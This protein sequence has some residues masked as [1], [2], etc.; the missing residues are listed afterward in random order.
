MSDTSATYDTT[1]TLTANEFTRAGYTFTG[2]NTEADGSGTSYEDG[3][4]VSNLTT[5]DGDTVTLY[6][7]WEANPATI[8]VYYIDK[9]TGETLDTYS[10]T[11]VYG[12][13]V[14]TSASDIEGYVLV[15]S[16]ETEEYILDVEDINVYYYY[17]ETV[18]VTITKV[19]QE[20]SSTT[21]SGVEFSLY[22]LICED[23]SHEHDTDEDLIDTEDY[24]TTTCWELVGE[25]TTDS[26]GEFELT[27]LPITR[28]YRLVETKTIENYL[29]PT[30]QWKIEFDYDDNLDESSSITIDDV[31]LQIT[32]IGNPPALSLQTVNGEDVLYLYN[33]VAYDIPTTGSYDTNN[34]YLVGIP[35]ML[36]GVLVLVIRKRQKHT[37][38]RYSSLKQSVHD[39]RKI[40]NN[41][42]KEV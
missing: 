26:N 3:A 42:D 30:G 27:N 8:N 41:W 9:I 10:Y 32:A 1:V 17:E 21:L 40:I 11:G 28:N 13:T 7:Q 6:A 23:D 14:T 38:G 24:D 25:Y 4:T 16:P 2:W 31:T 35:I 20:D 15:E 29:L 22:E 5:T 33:S 34:F 37:L 36:L 12:E 19:S 18:D 39:A